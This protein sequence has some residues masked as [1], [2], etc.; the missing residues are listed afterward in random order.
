MMAHRL[1]RWTNITQALGQCLVLAGTCHEGGGGGG[2]SR[3][4]Q[5]GRIALDKRASH[6]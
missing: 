6:N 4:Y 5:A 2:G 1:R 3:D